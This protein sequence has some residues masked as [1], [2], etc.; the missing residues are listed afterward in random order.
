MTCLWPTSLSETVSLHSMVIAIET[1]LNY[2]EN[3]GTCQGS[4]ADMQL[5][6]WKYILFYGFSFV[7]EQ[8]MAFIV[9]LATG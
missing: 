5:K 6:S 1:N 3:D 2:K 7:V 8:N 9:S 4:P